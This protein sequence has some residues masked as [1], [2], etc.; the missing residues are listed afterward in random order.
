MSASEKIDKYIADTDDWRGEI[1]ARLR[2]LVLE[3]DPDIVEEW[4]WNV[5]VWSHGKLVCSASAFKTHV[6]MNFFQG[7][8][9]DDPHTLFNSGL[10]AKK[11]RMVNFFEGDPVNEA[12]LQELIRTAINHN[13]GEK[14]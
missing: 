10:E 4:K 11:S 8:S 6:G 2:R 9:L 14:S 1:L 7:A 5:P 13:K 3:T 12:A